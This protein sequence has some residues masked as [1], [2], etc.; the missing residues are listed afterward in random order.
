MIQIKSHYG[1]WKIVTREQAEGFIKQIISG[2]AAVPT[3]AEQMRIIN[4]KH[5]RGITAEELLGYVYTE[6]EKPLQI[7]TVVRR[8][9]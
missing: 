3:K 8:R 6:N 2:F 4:E 5:L 7:R 9:S 1:D